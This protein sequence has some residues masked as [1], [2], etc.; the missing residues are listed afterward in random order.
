MRDFLGVDPEGEI[1]CQI[2][3]LQSYRKLILP[4]E[5]LLFRE[6]ENR[7]IEKRFMYFLSQENAENCRV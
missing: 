5:H 3:I 4:A 7:M 1:S 6:T 2:S